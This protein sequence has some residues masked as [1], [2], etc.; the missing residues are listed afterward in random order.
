MPLYTPILEATAV[1]TDEGRVY[2]FLMPEYDVYVTTSF[3]KVDLGVDVEMTNTAN[4]G[5]GT[6]YTGIKASANATSDKNITTHVNDNVYVRVAPEYGYV[7]KDLVAVY[8]DAEGDEVELPLTMVSQKYDKHDIYWTSYVARFTMPASSVTVRAT[9]VEDY[10]A[11]V[12]QDWDNTQLQV[13]NVDYKATPNLSA[14]FPAVTGRPGYHFV[15]WSSADV[16]TPVTAPSVDPADFVIVKDTVI[17]AVYEKD[18]YSIHYNAGPHG[19]FADGKTEQAEYLD[20]CSFT[21]VPE[22]GYMVDTVSATYVNEAGETI[23]IELIP[24]AKTV[25]DHAG[26]TAEAY[27]FRM[28]ACTDD[29]GVTVSA[30]FKPMT[31]DVT[32]QYNKAQ[33]ALRLNGEDVDAMAA[34]Y[35]DT[36]SVNVTPATGYML[37][38]LYYTCLLYTSPSPRDCS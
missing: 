15:G 16:E 22:T 1:D 28:P 5:K 23:A 19:S 13:Q 33:G 31:Y 35:T 4:T 10:Y 3:E 36:I 6:V 24:G 11:V 27:S 8:T 2:S 14:Q 7:L 21:A 20:L 32:S 26:T 38:Q 9:F 18:S 37:T 25:K 30:T 34:N 29:A 12:F 17:R